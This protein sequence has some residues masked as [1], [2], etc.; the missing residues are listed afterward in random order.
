MNIRPTY[1]AVFNIMHIQH[2]EIILSTDDILRK[3][4]V[5]E[6]RILGVLVK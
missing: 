2:V 3:S 6:C 1:M 5:T 4:F